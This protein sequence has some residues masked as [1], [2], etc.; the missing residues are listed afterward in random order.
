M[1]PLLTN[2]N[3]NFWWLVIYHFPKFKFEKSPTLV[4]L[5]CWLLTTTELRLIVCNNW[6]KNPP[7]SFIFLV[8]LLTDTVG[9]RNLL[10]LFIIAVLKISGEKKL[11][12]FFPKTRNQLFQ[13]EANRVL[14]TSYTFYTEVVKWTFWLTMI[15]ESS[16]LFSFII[17]KTPKSIPVH[18]WW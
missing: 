4:I 7:A 5:E 18:M 12:M 17:I 6:K 10:Y 3:T 15:R 9:F 11:V 16:F 2:W 1:L 14:E 13:N 8:R